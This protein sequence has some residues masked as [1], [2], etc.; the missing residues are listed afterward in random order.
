MKAISNNTGKRQAIGRKL[1]APQQ[2]CISY[3]ELMW[4][5]LKLSG[6]EVYAGMLVK[7]V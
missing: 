6:A 5:S 4:R 2:K 7:F 1:K 3:A